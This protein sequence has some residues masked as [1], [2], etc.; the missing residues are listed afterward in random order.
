MTQHEWIDSG[1]ES[2]ASVIDTQVTGFRCTAI[3]E[4]QT[5]ARDLEDELRWMRELTL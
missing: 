2:H 4:E 1:T 5:H 3:A